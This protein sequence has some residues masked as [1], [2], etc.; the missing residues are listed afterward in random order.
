MIEPGFP[1]TAIV[2][3]DAAAFEAFLAKT[4]ANLA[5]EGVRLAGLIQRSEARPGRLKCDLLLQDLAT[6]ERHAI[7]EDRG[8]LARGCVL[9]TDRL[10]RAC[11]AAASS[12][13]DQCDML[14]LS[15]FGKA[16]VEGGGFRALI[17]RAFELDVPVIIGVPQVNLPP[18]REFAAGLA[19]EIELSELAADP[20]PAAA[21]AP[22]QANGGAV[23]QPA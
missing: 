6:G 17:A 21:Q 23:A 2:Y 8:A 10:L 3:A 12:L 18:F 9:D 5:G 16:E 11:E 15:K 20:L 19:R 1:L 14:V 4:T 7:S 13:T 22:C